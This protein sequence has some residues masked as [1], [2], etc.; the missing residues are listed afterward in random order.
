MTDS[1][2]SGGCW[3]PQEL[4]Q[5]QQQSTARAL[6]QATTDW[7]TPTRICRIT[8]SQPTYY[9]EIRIIPWGVFV[10]FLLAALRLA[11]HYSLQRADDDDRPPRCCCEISNF[12]PVAA[13]AC[14]THYICVYLQSLSSTATI[15]LQIRTVLL[16]FAQ[17]ERDF[18]NGRVVSG[19]RGVRTITPP[20]TCVMMMII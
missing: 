12:F 18:A 15:S 20:F 16:A 3:S 11:R 8:T 19:R 9:N 10:L 17:K 6:Q 4:K 5:H 13:A 7:E 14:L 1:F 2:A